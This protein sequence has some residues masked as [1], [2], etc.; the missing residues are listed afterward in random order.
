M[1]R[2]AGTRLAGAHM[3]AAPSRAARSAAPSASIISSATVT[4]SRAVC[5]LVAGMRVTHAPS[6][7]ISWRRCGSRRGGRGT[8]WI[9]C[10][11]SERCS[12]SVV[13]Q[14]HPSAQVQDVIGRDPRL[15]AA[16]RSSTARADAWRR[17]DRSSRA[18]SCPR[19]R[20][21][22]CRLC[23]MNVGVRSAEAPRPRTASPWSPRAPPRVPSPVK[24]PSEPSHALAAMRWP[25]HGRARASSPVSVSIH[26]VVICAL[27][28]V[29]SHY[30][31]SSWGLL[32]LHGL[33][34]C[35]AIIFRA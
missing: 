2:R 21:G 11:H 33:I 4:C 31:C 30:D 7:T 35:A 29:K 14:P 6:P 20:G 1:S 23:Q 15:R 28:L 25:D 17:R 8:A 5:W 32:K 18:S 13:S 22:F 3:C 26:S 10:C 16:D 9:R 24:R 34:T 27:L 19:L 12:P